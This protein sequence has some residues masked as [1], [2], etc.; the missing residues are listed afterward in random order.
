MKNNKRDKDIVLKLTI[1]VL[2]VFFGIVLLIDQLDNGNPF[3][4]FVDDLFAPWY[5][6]VLLF[7]AACLLSYAII[8]KA[9]IMYVL[10]MFFAG[11]FLTISVGVKVDAKYL[12]AV[13]F[14]VP[15]LVGIG[16][17][18][19]DRVCK[20]SPKILRFGVV[21]TVASVVV[22]ISVILEVWKYVIPIVIVLIGIAY[23]I[24]ELF[25]LKQEN[26]EQPD[27]HY[28]T[29]EPKEQCDKD[30]IEADITTDNLQK[31]ENDVETK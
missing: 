17:V 31:N 6:I 3:V 9:P 20:W 29:Y 22:L 13:I 15:M 14:I 8:K 1:S 10:S 26:V 23:F 12:G 25:A 5:T 19:A 30:K 21:L 7:V 16:F 18:I 4:Q 28:V 2:L 11:L 24:F 27:D